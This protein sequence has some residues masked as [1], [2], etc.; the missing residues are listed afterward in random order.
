MVK[1]LN[2]E[3]HHSLLRILENFEEE[4]VMENRGLGNNSHLRIC[5]VRLTN[6][7]VGNKYD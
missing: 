3:G 6:I 4:N 5:R 1:D 2:G 7:H